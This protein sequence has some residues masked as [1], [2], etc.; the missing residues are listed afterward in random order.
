MLKMMARVTATKLFACSMP[1]IDISPRLLTYTIIGF[2]V[3]FLLT[4]VSKAR[5]YSRDMRRDELAAGELFQKKN[6]DAIEFINQVNGHSHWHVLAICSL[7]VTACVATVACVV[8]ATP[9]QCLTPTGLNR[10]LITFFI[11][12]I[13]VWISM[14]Q[15]ISFFKYHHLRPSV[16]IYDESHA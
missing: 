8:L 10:R 4:A 13:V 2:M 7:A 1:C 12:W 14:C 16:R 9:G 6:R 5:G 15:V 11:A 3:T